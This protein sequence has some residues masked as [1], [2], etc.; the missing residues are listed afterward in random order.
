[1][2]GRGPQIPNETRI[3]TF[4]LFSLD[5]VV[6]NESTEKYGERVWPATG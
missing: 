2:S 4:K 6:T 5:K 3:I 1:M